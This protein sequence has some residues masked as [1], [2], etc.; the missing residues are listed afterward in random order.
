MKNAHGLRSTME[1]HAKTG[2][3]KWRTHLEQ[4]IPP[5]MREAVKRNNSINGAAAFSGNYQL[6]FTCYSYLPVVLQ[7]K[8]ARSKLCLS[9][10]NVSASQRQ[11]GRQLYLSLLEV[12]TDKKKSLDYFGG[13]KTESELFCLKDIRLLRAQIT[14]MLL[15][16]FSPS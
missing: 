8:V 3:N 7:G 15:L 4:D 9:K 11:I 6:F 2:I 16:L 5:K 13:A 14:S 10:L 12:P 1:H